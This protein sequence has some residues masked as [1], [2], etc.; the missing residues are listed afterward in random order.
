MIFL[1]VGTQEPFDRLVQAVDRWAA[2]S[3][4]SAIFGQI[5]DRGLYR[6]RNF[7]WAA[8]LDITRYRSVC[9]QASLLVAHA[10]MGSIITALDYAKPIVIMPRR[11]HLGEHR[12]DHQYA[13]ARQF[14]GKPGI[15]VADDE[16]ALAAE[17][18]KARGENAVAAGKP[19]SPYAQERL[20]RF[21]SDYFNN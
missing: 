20:V 16:N 4:D 14:R 21:L 13:T 3:R 8:H 18:E 5:S 6:P 10:G 19:H 12:N 15:H 2:E 7:E 9:E 17:I 1:T 11:S